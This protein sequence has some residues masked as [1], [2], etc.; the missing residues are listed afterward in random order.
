MNTTELDRYTQRGHGVSLISNIPQLAVEKKYFKASSTH[1]CLVGST[2]DDELE[3][4][5][6]FLKDTEILFY[7]NVFDSTKKRYHEFLKTLDD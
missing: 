2:I 3:R 6:E 4:R 1:G 7:A 5:L